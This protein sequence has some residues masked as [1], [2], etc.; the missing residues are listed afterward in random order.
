M[1]VWGK[2]SKQET[3]NA[4]AFNILIDIAD[5]ISPSLYLNL[6][7]ISNIL[8]TGSQIRLSFTVVF[9]SV[10][11]ALELHVLLFY[12]DFNFFPT[13]HKSTAPSRIVHLQR[14]R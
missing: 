8:A 1:G 13:W 11:S 4:Q 7:E 6:N 10:K 2:G 14:A 12:R 3:L 5:E 9:K